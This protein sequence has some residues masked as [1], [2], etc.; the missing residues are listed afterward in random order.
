M[1]KE[2]SYAQHFSAWAGLITGP[3]AW[4]I[5]TQLNFALT[6][7]QCVNRVYPIPWIA[8]LLALLSLSGGHVSLQYRRQADPSETS[9][10][11]ASLVATLTSLLFMMII[12]LQGFAGLIFTGCER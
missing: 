10:L 1:V 9:L 12:L 4:A 6:S 2:V 11:F 8:L 7:W 3:V 5:S